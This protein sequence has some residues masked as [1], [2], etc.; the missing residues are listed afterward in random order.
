MFI[1]ARQR[2]L[3]KIVTDLGMNPETIPDTIN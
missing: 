2:T 1:A 3:V